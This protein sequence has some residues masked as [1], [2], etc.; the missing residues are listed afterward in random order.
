[1]I[2][3]C[4]FFLPSLLSLFSLS[5]C[6]SVW[7]RAL[8]AAAVSMEWWQKAVVV[9]VKRAWIAAAARLTTRHKKEGNIS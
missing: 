7:Q 2:L 6:L 8:T 9:P 5:L 1:L 4:S 3:S